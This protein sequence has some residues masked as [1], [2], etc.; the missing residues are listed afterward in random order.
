MNNTREAWLHR[1]IDELR[2][3]FEAAC[4]TLPSVIHVSVGLPK[5][6]NVI[7]QCW[8]G[9][10][11]EDGNQHVF[12]SPVLVEPVEVLDTLTHELIH[13]VMPSDVGH[14]KAFVKAGAA[15]GMTE[16]RAKS[17]GAGPELAH[18]LRTELAPKLGEYPHSKLDTTSQA[19]P[20]GTRL[21]KAECAI[22]GYTV[23]VTAKWL[24]YAGAPLCPAEA[25]EKQ[26][27]TCDWQGESE[28]ENE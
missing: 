2:P 8:H 28:G 4:L 23:R 12:I 16:G 21:L 1:A 11:S 15:L 10:R 19:K 18:W 6:R 7:G 24:G 9:D 27:M 22:C 3:R 17:L 26:A 25:C 14:K 5:G 13:V 20:Q